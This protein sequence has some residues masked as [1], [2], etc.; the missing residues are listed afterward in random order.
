MISSDFDMVECLYIEGDNV[1]E[2]LPDPRNHKMESF[3]NGNCFSIKFENCFSVV[4][5]LFVSVVVIFRNNS[6]KNGFLD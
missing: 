2:I 6:C 1:N 5:V 4:I 3:D